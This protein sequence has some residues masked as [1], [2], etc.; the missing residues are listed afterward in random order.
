LLTHRF[1]LEN[2]AEAYELFSSG[3][4]RVLKVALYPD[5]RALCAHTN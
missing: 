4:D 5:A 1:T 2:I 3:R